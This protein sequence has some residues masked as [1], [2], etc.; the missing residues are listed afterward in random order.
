M[1][2]AACSLTEVGMEVGMTQVEF[3]PAQEVELVD[4]EAKFPRD[5]GPMEG[6]RFVFLWGFLGFPSAGAR[7]GMVFKVLSEWV[8]L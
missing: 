6:G 1:N 5:V 4:S 8:C 3:V 7:H 2:R